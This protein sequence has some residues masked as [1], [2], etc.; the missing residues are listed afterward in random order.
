M[1]LSKALRLGSSPAVAF[2]GAGGKTTALFKLAH[3][4]KSCVVTTTTHLGSWQIPQK[5]RH[6]VWPSGRPLSYFSDSI[7][8]GL[9]LMTGEIEDDR[10]RGLVDSQI[11]ELRKLTSTKSL[12]LL[13]EADGARQKPVKAPA[14]HEPVIP[15]FVDLVVVMV[16]IS[17][18]GK[19][20]AEE[21]VHR[22]GQ[23]SELSGLEVGQPINIEALAKVISHPLG[24]LKDIPQRSRKI[25]LINQADSPELQAQS[26]NLTLRILPFFDGVIIASLGYDTKNEKD[27]R[28]ILAVYEQTAGIVL[29]AGG[30]TRYGQPK[31]LLDY[32]G[33]PFIRVVTETALAAGLSPVVAVL[34]SSGDDVRSALDGLNVEI[35]FNPNWEMGQSTSINAGIERLPE[36]TGGAIFLLADQPQVTVSV[37]YSLMEKHYEELPPVIAPYI[38]D[39]RANPVLFDRVTFEDLKHLKGDQGG[40]AIFSKFQPTYVNWADDRLLL[41][42]DS[43]ED[44]QI[45]MDRDRDG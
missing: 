20:L 9:T 37:L 32:R 4:Y 8:E 36:N 28:S 23:F 19:I 43:P 44:Y 11:T 6:I 27:A 40:R 26:K 2:V 18:L 33:K 31:Q 14:H 15:N 38:L 29:A 3:E 24:G 5:S 39:R 17:G 34:G 45:L 16:G 21:N 7:D 10:Y 22:P 13:I 42:V 25:A 41:D 1:N 35:V 30:S 12:P